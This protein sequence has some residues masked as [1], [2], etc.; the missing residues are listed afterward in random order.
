MEPTLRDMDD[1]YNNESPQKKRIVNLV[2]LGLFL[3]AL[4]YG[5]V[6]VYYDTHMPSSFSPV[7]TQQEI[8]ATRGY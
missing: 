6:K 8:Q 3:C 4:A 7:L 1:Y 5:G 2:V